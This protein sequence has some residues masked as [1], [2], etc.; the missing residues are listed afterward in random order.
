MRFNVAQSRDPRV[1]E[2][3]RQAMAIMRQQGGA[4]TARD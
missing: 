4:A 2:V 1:I 3:L